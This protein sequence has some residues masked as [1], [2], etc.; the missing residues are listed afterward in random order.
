MKSRS[1]NLADGASLLFLARLLFVLCLHLLDEGAKGAYFVVLV[2]L[3]VK[4]VLLTEAQLKQVVVERLLRHVDFCSSVFKRI[5][6]QVPVPEN[7]VIEAS[8]Q[9][10]LLDDFFD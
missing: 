7:S 6:N 2:L 8:P 1:A 4:V 5:P 10:D 3:E 9:T